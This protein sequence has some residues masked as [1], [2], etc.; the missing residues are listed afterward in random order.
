M[1][2]HNQLK[3]S[4]ALQ[5]QPHVECI[6]VVQIRG[7]EDMSN[8]EQ[9]LP[10]EE[11]V[12]LMHHPK[13]CNGLPGHGPLLVSQRQSPNCVLGL[14]EAMSSRML[15]EKYCH[16]MAQ[17]LHSCLSSVEAHRI[18]PDP[19]GLQALRQ[20]IYSIAQAHWDRDIKLG[21]ISILMILNPKL[22]DHLTQQL[23]VNI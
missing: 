15:V 22:S 8:C 7:P 19:Y 11:Q 23:H 2:L 3:L 17:Y 10:I 5:W 20:D 13:V 18:N 4:V 12:Q 6:A 16:Q 9:S 1:Q 21:I 14:S